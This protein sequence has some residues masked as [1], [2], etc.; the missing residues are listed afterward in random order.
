M[1]LK[2]MP[3]F[4]ENLLQANRWK[5]RG[6]SVVP[7]KFAISYYLAHYN[8]IVNIYAGDGSISVAHGGIEC[9]QGINTKVYMSGDTL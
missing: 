2:G 6:L 5:K 9:G 3:A 8:A 4:F 7:M 1:K